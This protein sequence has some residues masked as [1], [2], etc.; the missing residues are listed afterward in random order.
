MYDK[1][2]KAYKATHPAFEEHEETLDEYEGRRTYLD[3]AQRHGGDDVNMPSPPSTPSDIHD[4]PPPQ[5]RMRDEEM[6][7]FL[8]LSAAL[9]V[10]LART[11]H[12]ADLPRAK[13]LLETY[14]LN[15]V[16]VSCQPLSPLGLC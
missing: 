11:I 6:T 1:K 9:T 5:P 7:N 4:N 16:E 13:E 10:L 3:F 8:N 14:L 2:L 15:I 12:K